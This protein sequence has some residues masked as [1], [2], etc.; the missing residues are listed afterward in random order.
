MTTREHD[1][2][3]TDGA[4]LFVQVRGADDSRPVIIPNG[5]YFVD[6]L[7]EPL[8]GRTVVVYDLRNR[9]RSETITD[10][11]RLSR[12]VDNDVDDLETVRR[13]CG[14]DRVDIL[15][16]SYV[17]VVPILYAM[18]FPGHVTRVIQIG[19]SAPNP[20]T[21]YPA[22]LSAQDET[23]REVVASVQALQGERAAMAPQ[24]FCEKVW[25]ML[26]PIY[27]ADAAN[28]ARI[29]WGRCDLP[30]ER[31]FMQYWMAHVFPSLQRLSP[32]D[33]D[34]QRVTSPVL[35]IHGRRDRSAPYGGG[36]EW[37]WRLPNARLLTVDAAG[38][39]PWIES[40]DIVLPAIATF[41][42]GQWPERAEQV[43]S[44]DGA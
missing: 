38:H 20:S 18:R 32:R 41:L 15:A 4:H 9:G 29:R 7:A 37:A 31:A 11:A 3:M 13:F 5:P 44:L 27:V 42:D 26:R 17:A 8:N 22:H 1:V 36:R 21:Q 35:T 6:D 34:L 24:E 23:V 25:A 12:G 10:A 30:N 14:F 43:T 19:P 28:V 2:T 33:A 39:A 16:H 40:P